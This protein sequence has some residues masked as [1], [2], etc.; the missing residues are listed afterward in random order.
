[1]TGITED[2]ISV[3]DMFYLC[4]VAYNT[5]FSINFIFLQYFYEYFIT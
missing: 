5:A 2:S 4:S 1:M 3:Q